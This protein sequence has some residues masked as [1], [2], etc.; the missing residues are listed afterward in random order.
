MP[1]LFYLIKFVVLLG[2]ILVGLVQPAGG[3][4]VESPLVL[5]LPGR[6]VHVPPGLVLDHACQRLLIVLQPPLVF[7]LPG[8]HGD[9]PPGLLLTHGSP[10]SC[11]AKAP[12]MP[13]YD[14]D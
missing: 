12:L 8:R 2:G 7:L 10:G 5:L 3:G 14:L 4:L 13:Q 1:L 9:L 11:L 6:Y